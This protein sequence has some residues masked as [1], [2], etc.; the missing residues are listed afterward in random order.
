M[1][2]I[3]AYKSK[4]G[5]VNEELLK[6]ALKALTQEGIE[7]TDSY[8]DGYG[9]S[10]K[11]STEGKLIGVLKTKEVFRGIGIVIDKKGKL[12]FVGDSY[13]YSQAFESL[14]KRIER[15]YIELAVLQALKQTGFKVKIRKKEKVGTVLEGEK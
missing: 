2:H 4:L 13:G 10:H 6:L 12:K 5:Q 15:M 14:K 8:S 3:A 7:L 11:D 1:S 9:H